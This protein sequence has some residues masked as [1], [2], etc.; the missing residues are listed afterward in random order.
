ME[1]VS[2]RRQ[3][4]PIREY[5]EKLEWDGIKR[6]DLALHHYLGADTSE[7]TQAVTRKTLV[8]ACKR[9]FEPGCKFDYVL[10]LVGAEGKGKSQFW[11]ILGG[12][13]YSDTTLEFGGKGKDAMEQI[14]FAWIYEIG[15]LAGIRKTDAESMK[16]FISSTNDNYREAYGRRTVPH[17][18]Q[19][20]FVATT[21]NYEFLRSSN[22]NRRWWVVDIDVC[23]TKF[24]D[25]S[26]M[27]QQLEK[28]RDQLWAEAMYYYRKG[29]LLY[30]DKTDLEAEAVKLQNTHNEANTYAIGSDIDQYLKIPLP[31]DWKSRDTD[32]RQCYYQN[33][34][35]DSSIYEKGSVLRTTVIYEE[36][37]Y[38]WYRRDASTYKSD[39]DKS[40][41]DKVMRKN[42]DWC[43]S[44]PTSYVPYKDNTRVW[45][46]KPDKIETA[47]AKIEEYLN[48]L[49]SGIEDDDDI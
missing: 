19:L 45:K 29:E 27:F 48:S 16:A 14:R 9:V 33:I 7:Y 10:T 47:K 12:T 1:I 36:F 44:N 18:R 6:L 32:R 11:H 42:T 4:H 40:K 28:D 46:M 20:I 23:P 41:F 21:N 25:T 39:K 49:T 30:L 5:L 34:R 17:P 43:Q 26:M 37:A 31:I 22:G 2:T 13:W 35:H 8:A 38:E 15:D 3:V 24:D